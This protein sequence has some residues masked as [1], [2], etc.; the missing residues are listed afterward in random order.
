[1]TVATP[2][3]LEDAA[4]SLARAKGIAV[5]AKGGHIEGEVVTD[6]LVDAG[7]G[8]TRLQSRRIETRDTHGTGCTLAS[9]IACGL[10]MGM[11]M[12][13]AV[14]RARDYT[15]AAIAAAPGFGKGHGPMGH[16][17]GKAHFD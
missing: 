6:I 5:L 7:G 16:S 9:G 13:S 11:D 14:H 10:G 4:R 15:I 12:E 3:Q 17:L 8:T 1:V 2:E